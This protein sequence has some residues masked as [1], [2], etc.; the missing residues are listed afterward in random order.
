MPSA[1]GAG[2]FAHL[3]HGTHDHQAVLPRAHEHPAGLIR[4]RR[5][6]GRGVRACGRAKRLTSFAFLCRAGVTFFQMDK[7]ELLILMYTSSAPRPA[8]AIAASTIDSTP[9]DFCRPDHRIVDVSI[10]WEGLTQAAHERDR[11]SRLT[12]MKSSCPAIS[13]PWRYPS[14]S[15]MMTIPLPD[16]DEAEAANKGQVLSLATTQKSILRINNKG[17]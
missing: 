16:D 15:A 8:P 14:S 4:E 17:N 7:S 10:R 9:S 5:V 11:T 13:T 2:P 12:V 6:G 1:G 3:R